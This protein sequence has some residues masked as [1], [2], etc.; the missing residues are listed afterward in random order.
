M[1]AFAGDGHAVHALGL[2]SLAAGRAAEAR[3]LFQRALA[4]GVAGEL[5]AALEN[6]LGVSLSALGDLTGARAALARAV[7]QDP[8]L[9]PAREN[10]R[11]LSPPPEV[12]SPQP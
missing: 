9:A 2:A 12:A 7:E 11:A 10:L 5:L 6:D 8:G 4:V 3:S 1:A